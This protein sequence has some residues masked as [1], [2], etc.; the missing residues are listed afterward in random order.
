MLY[1]GWR[2]AWNGNHLWSHFWLLAACKLRGE[3]PDLADICSVKNAP[4]R[5]K[6][7]P[8][9]LLASCVL[10][11]ALCLVWLFALAPVQATVLPRHEPHSLP[12]EW[13]IVYD[14]ASCFS[15][16]FR[17]SFWCLFYCFSSR[18]TFPLS[19]SSSAW[20]QLWI[21]SFSSAW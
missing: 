21:P 20:P 14:A 9:L 11:T 8:R 5:L 7:G 6:F 15:S 1:G 16:S 19:T 4:V 3:C 18:W 10:P 13:F 17:P 2:A 12:S